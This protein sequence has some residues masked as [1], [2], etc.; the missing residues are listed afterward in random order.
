MKRVIF[1]QLTLIVMPEPEP[2]LLAKVDIY[3]PSGRCKLHGGWST[4]PKTPEGKKRSAQN[5][6]KKKTS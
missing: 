5:G 4:G 6:F 1:L 3:Y 2:E